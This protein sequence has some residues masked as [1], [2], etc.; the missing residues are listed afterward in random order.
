MFD[1]IANLVKEV[2]CYNL[3][4]DKSGQIVE[5]LEKSNP[6]V[7]LPEGALV[8]KFSITANIDSGTPPN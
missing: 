1:F 5:L 4:F 8:A 7:G 3:Y 2:P 6:G